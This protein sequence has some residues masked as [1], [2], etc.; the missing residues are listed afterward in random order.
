VSFNSFSCGAH[1]DG[2]RNERD[3][4]KAHDAGTKAGDALVQLA[5]DRAAA[6]GRPPIPGAVA[7][8]E[9][10]RDRLDDVAKA[11]GFKNDGRLMEAQQLAEALA[12]PEPRAAVSPPAT[13]EPA[14]WQPHAGDEAAAAGAA[15]LMGCTPEEFA[16]A[17]RDAAAGAPGHL[18]RINDR[19][20][21]DAVRRAPRVPIEKMFCP[22]PRIN[23]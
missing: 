16:S 6:L 10:E 3:L 17:H 5:H 8:A 13:P 2:D 9:A 15:E 1:L 11:T 18:N 7:A 12:E 14:R 20:V 19:L 23:P 4:A 22:R 21:A